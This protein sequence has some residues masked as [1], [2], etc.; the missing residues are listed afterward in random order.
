[1][2]V[3]VK[4]ET[5]LAMSRR[6]AIVD[7]QSAIQALPTEGA[8]VVQITAEHC[9]V[10]HHFAPHSYGRE[11]FLPRGTVVVGKIHRHAHINVI[12]QGRVRVF[13]ESEGALEF[14]APYT[15]VSSPG[16][17]RAVEVLKDTI[18]TTIH[19]VSMASPSEAD[20]PAIEQEV[21]TPTFLEDTV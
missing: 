6:E 2:E 18:W 11:I 20:L 3:Q 7:L 19:S 4:P 21:I 9:P 12:S 16:T 15:F 10:R 5:A 1:M 14:Q 17:K 8:D 13:T